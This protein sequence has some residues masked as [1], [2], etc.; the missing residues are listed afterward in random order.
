M[1]I[2]LII[3]I[4]FFILGAWHASKQTDEWH[5]EKLSDAGSAAVGAAAGIAAAAADIIKD[6]K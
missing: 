2:F 6:G 5:R 3:F 4:T 1:I